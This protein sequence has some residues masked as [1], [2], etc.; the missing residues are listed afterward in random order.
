MEAASSA[1]EPRQVR[2]IIWRFAGPASGTVA[3]A[4]SSLDSPS[5][6]LAGVCRLRNDVVDVLRELLN[7]ITELHEPGRLVSAAVQ[8]K[9]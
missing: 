7:I 6:D 1:P 8:I 9:F 5:C 3:R 2:L 4:Y